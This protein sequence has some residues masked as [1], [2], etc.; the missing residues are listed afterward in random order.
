MR[1]I[2]EC[3]LLLAALL[4]AAVRDC[5]DVVAENPLLRHQLAVLPL[6]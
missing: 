2:I 3:L 6:W 1:A 4:R 5:G